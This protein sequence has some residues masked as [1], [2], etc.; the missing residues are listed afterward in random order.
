M[1]VLHWSCWCTKRCIFWPLFYPM[2]GYEKSSLFEIWWRKKV[3]TY[4][5]KFY[6]ISKSSY[7]EH[8]YACKENYWRKSLDLAGIKTTGCC[9]KFMDFQDWGRRGTPTPTTDCRCAV[10]SFI[11]LR[12]NSQVV[13]PTPVTF[14]GGKR[15]W[16]KK[17]AK[18]VTPPHFYAYRDLLLKKLDGGKLK[19]WWR[20]IS[21]LLGFNLSWIKLKK[22]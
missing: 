20:N 2:L 19:K 21:F 16:F 15:S 22:S 14:Q 11:L 1:I 7:A 8:V 18:L 3:D 17:P 12:Y 10:M 5:M 4:K 13:E 6:S 9:C